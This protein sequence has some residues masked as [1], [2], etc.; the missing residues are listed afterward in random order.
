MNELKTMTIDTL[1]RAEKALRG[2]RAETGINLRD[3]DGTWIV[4]NPPRYRSIYRD[5]ESTRRGLVTYS[6]STGELR[7]YGMLVQQDPSLGDNE[8][9]LRSEVVA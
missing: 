9:R 1:D 8:V 7:L 3:H 4:V 2:Y 6:V 5:L